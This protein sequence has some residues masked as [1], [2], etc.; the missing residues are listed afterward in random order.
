MLLII[1][2]F[3][4]QWTIFKISNRICIFVQMSQTR[5]LVLFN[6]ISLY[7]T[8]LMK[9]IILAILCSLLFHRWYSWLG[10]K[11]TAATHLVQTLSS[12]SALFLSNRLKVHA[13][14]AART[15]PN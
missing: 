4:K 5:A 3:G 15:P 10:V 2:N 12:P 6:L 7:V 13:F 11:D 8:T 9:Y 14:V 1:S